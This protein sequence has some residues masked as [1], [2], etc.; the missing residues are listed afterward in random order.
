MERKKL[1]D[2]KGIEINQLKTQV[3]ELMTRRT[4]ISGDEE[5]RK[6][7]EQLEK[8]KTKLVSENNRLRGERNNY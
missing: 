3:F 8:D 7:K 2:Q 1:L 5:L 6:E 4:T